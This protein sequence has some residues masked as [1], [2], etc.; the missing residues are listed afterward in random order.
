ML[1]SAVTP[2]RSHADGEEIDPYTGPSGLVG[3]LWWNVV[4]SQRKFYDDLR[5]PPDE[6]NLTGNPD[7]Y[8]SKLFEMGITPSVTYV[9]DT[10]GNPFGGKRQG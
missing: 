7:H 5:L 6:R 1:L 8:R 4:P 10:V 3:Y 9:T 2:P